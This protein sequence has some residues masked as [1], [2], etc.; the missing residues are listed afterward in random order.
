M[1]ELIA[2][3]VLLEQRTIGVIIRRITVGQPTLL[4]AIVNREPC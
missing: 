3:Y 2:E 4:S 1:S